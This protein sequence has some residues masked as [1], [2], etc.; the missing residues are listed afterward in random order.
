M[1]EEE[2]LEEIEKNN[3]S[4]N[5]IVEVDACEETL[6]DME[7]VKVETL[8]NKPKKNKKECFWKKLS[9]KNK[10]IIIV[11]G[12]IF[13]L[14]IIALLLYFLVFKKE[15]EKTT[16]REPEVIIEKENYRYKNGSLVF[17]D[18]NDKEIGTYECNNKDEKSCYVVNYSTEDEFDVT[19]KIKEDY[20][21][22]EYISEIFNNQY[23]FVY[24]NKDENGNIILYDM[25]SNE[26]IDE[27]KLVKKVTDELVIL[28]DTNDKYGVINLF[29]ELEN[30]V[31]FECDYIG[32]IDEKENLIARKDGKS[33]LL[34]MEGAAV[35]DSIKGNIKN[36]DNKYISIENDGTYYIYNYEGIVVREMEISHIAFKEGYVFIADGKNLY[37]FD[38]DMNPL[39]LEGIKLKN[40]DYNTTIIF[41]ENLR[42]KER[43]EAYYVTIN[44]DNISIETEDD[45]E[46]VN[47][48][49]GKLNSK[50]DYVSYYDGILYLY[51]DEDKTEEFA[52]YKCNN[53]NVV[54]SESTEF[55]NCF[56]AKESALLNRGTDTSNI[57]YLP[58][59]N[60]RFAFIKDNQNVSVEDSILLWDFETNKKKAT[61]TSVD[62]GYYKNNNSVNFVTTAS[63]LVMAKNTSGSFGIINIESN[64]VAS[65]I[66]FKN[67]NINNESIKYLNDNFL[68]KRTDGSY[69]L[70]DNTGKEL[71]SSDQEI[72]DYN[73]EILLLK[74]KSDKYSISTI[75]GKV[76]G[77]NFDYVE[78]KKEY[79][80]GITGRVINVYKYEENAKGL[81]ETEVKI[82]KESYSDSYRVEGTNLIVDDVIYPI[83][84]ESG[85]E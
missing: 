26:V 13:L 24:D 45:I 4:S 10:I 58:V 30:T 52:T 44:V 3:T 75:A 16:T 43:K 19:K 34:D 48:Y 31:K 60:E 20:S 36:F 53:L 15:E 17:L 49:E 50:Y 79:F 33:L 47:V 85:A 37:T 27:Y 29:G 76:I 78:L 67:D 66:K 70:Y 38:S 62:T 9:K 2:I 23:A 6:Y 40:S 51:K 21:E 72:L 65:V 83:V 59:F 54:T 5:E 12:S 61:Y 25:T 55:E 14:A 74:N 73:T 42:E 18:D 69:Y 8:K 7:Q 32:Y 81:I 1:L 46:L 56:V 22:I 84:L 63:T 35:S 28:K 82:T 57:G 41:D 71:A 39:N 80:V 64:D 68:V 11:V 77:S